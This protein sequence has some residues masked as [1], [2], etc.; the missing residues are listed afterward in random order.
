MK[1]LLQRTNAAN[2]KVQ[3]EQ[4]GVIG[5]GLLLLVGFGKTDDSSKLKTCAEKICNL[6]I[7]SNQEGKFDKSVM[8]IGG[9]IL[10]VPQF[11]LFA[12]TSKG[13]RPEFFDA[14]E[15]K[16][17]SALFDELCNVFKELG[18]KKVQCGS[19]GAHMQ[20]TLENDGPVTMMLEF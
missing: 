11:T 7:F 4:V 8:D 6:R 17:A 10:L 16:K 1:I 12:D 18:I 19:F 9:E 14:L 20:V 13:R 3:E 2:V 15:P 5:R